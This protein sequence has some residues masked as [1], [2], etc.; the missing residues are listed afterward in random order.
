MADHWTPTTGAYAVDTTS[1][2]IGEVSK[3]FEGVAYLVPPGGGA[4]WA[5]DPAALRSP[6]DAETWQAQV[7]TRPVGSL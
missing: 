3:L 6:T 1:G 4:E 2:R 5:V 7:W